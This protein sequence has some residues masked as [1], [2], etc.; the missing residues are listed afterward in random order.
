MIIPA[1]DVPPMLKLETREQKGMSEHEEERS[2]LGIPFSSLFIGKDL[3]VMWR[4]KYHVII[5][6]LSGMFCSLF[7]FHFGG[8]H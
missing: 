7:F 4:K 5:C 2:Y 6:A 8:M 1:K 3:D